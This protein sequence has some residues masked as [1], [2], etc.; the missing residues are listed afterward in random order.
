[1]R[2]RGFTLIEL[3]V[4]I[5]IIAVLIALL[6]P[7]VQAARE[8]ARR[9]QC[10]NNLKQLGLAISSYTDSNGALPPTANTSPSGNPSQPTNDFSLKARILPF[11]EQSQVWNSLNQ[12][13]AINTVTNYTCDCIQVNTL[14]CPSDANIPCTTVTVSGPGVMQQNYTS[15]PNNVGT[16]FN[17]AINGGQH[18]GPTYHMGTPAQGPVCTL[19]SITD[20]TSNTAIFS[21]FVRGKYQLTSTV[22]GVWRVYNS[23]SAWPASVST[24]ATQNYDFYYQGCMTSTTVYPNYD[25]KGRLA[26]YGFCGAGGCY[27]HIM[28]PNS[29]AC[30]FSSDGEQEGRTLV[31]ASSNHNGGVNMACLDGSVKFIKSSISR[32][33]WRALA[34]KDKGEVIDASSY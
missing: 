6:L 20:G 2:R 1:M 12:T 3:L 21:E 10:V 17:L 13:Y 28:P 7:A 11:M 27:S 16:M 18:D 14:L 9:S 22:G 24:S 4:V 32:P 26:F 34:T 25:Q 5:A 31:G 29:K 15:Y 33:T 30:F 19:A 8:A 23:T